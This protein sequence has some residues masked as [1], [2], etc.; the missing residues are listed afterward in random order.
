MIKLVV[1]VKTRA[2][3]LKTGVGGDERVVVK[4]RSAVVETS[5]GGENDIIGRLGSLYPCV[6]S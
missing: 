6:V 2:V 1:I 4:T 3:V 5:D